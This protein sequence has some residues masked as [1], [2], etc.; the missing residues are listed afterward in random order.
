MVPR[1]LLQ[2]RSKLSFS[3]I[4]NSVS[5][6]FTKISNFETPEKLKGTFL[7]RWGLYWK[8]LYIDYKD[9]TIDVIKTCKEQPLRASVYTS[10]LGSS[11]YLCKHNPDEASFR[12]RLLQDAIKVLQVGEPIRNPI[13]ENHLK[14]LEKCY[15]EGIIRYINLGIISFIWLDNYEEGCSL[16]KAVCPYLKPRYVTLYQRVI[17]VG[18]LDKWWVLDNKMKDYDIN[19]DEFRNTQT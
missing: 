3:Q 12:E 10:L 19:E 14:W 15:N 5:N 9:V 7:E 11:Y 6:V 16:Y 18:I 13:S 17:D 1:H 8:N 2:L 4:N